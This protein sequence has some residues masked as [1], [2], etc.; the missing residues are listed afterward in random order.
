MVNKNLAELAAAPNS[1]YYPRVQ[2]NISANTAEKEMVLKYKETGSVCRDV[3]YSEDNF[4]FNDG[5]EILPIPVL[6]FVSPLNTHQFFIHVVLSLG[7]YTTEMEVLRNRSPREC[8]KKARLIGLTT[9]E[10]SRK[11]DSSQLLRNYIESQ[12]V[13]YPNSM[14]KTDKFIV[15]AERLFHDIILLDEFSVNEHPFTMTEL[16][17]ANEVEQ[18][19]FWKENNKSLLTVIFRNIHSTAGIPTKEEVLSCS[20]YNP[21]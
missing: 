16:L 15:A 12:V 21:L 19:Q 3:R 8:F 2:F 4:V 13:Y 18:I 10:S 5:N 17:N 9:D 1:D 7:K 20:R 14:V 11:E 6:S